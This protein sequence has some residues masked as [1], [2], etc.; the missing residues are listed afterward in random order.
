M[1]LSVLLIF[2]GLVVAFMNAAEILVKPGSK[3]EL[4]LSFFRSIQV[5]VGITS[6]LVAV[7][8][9]FNIWSGDYPLLTWIIV[10]VN[11]IIILNDFLIMR[12][13]I[14][15]GSPVMNALLFLTHFRKY[16]GMTALVLVVIKIIIILAPLFSSII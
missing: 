11:S 7:A 9:A 13:S 15:E 10:L 16:F 4:L 1:V 14:P 8:N 2:T 3:L 12:L 6:G 5:P